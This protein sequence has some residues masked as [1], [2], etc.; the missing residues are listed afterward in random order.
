MTMLSTVS[1][2]QTRCSQADSAA[3]VIRTSSH[4][5]CS[6]VSGVKSA[7]LL[8]ALT[9]VPRSVIKYLHK[10]QPFLTHI[11][12]P[13]YFQVECLESAQTLHLSSSLLTPTSISNIRK[14]FQS[15]NLFT[16]NVSSLLSSYRTSR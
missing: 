11:L 10:L 14:Q 7:V 15:T 13:F 3:C 9:A 16:L 12:T 2:V 8:S 5:S 1:S 6:L 4:C